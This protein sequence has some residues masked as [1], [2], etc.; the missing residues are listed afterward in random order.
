[1]GG[2]DYWALRFGQES[3]LVSAFVVWVCQGELD[4]DEEDCQGE[5]GSTRA[6]GESETRQKGTYHERRTILVHVMFWLP[7]P[8]DTIHFPSRPTAVVL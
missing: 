2:E 7:R 6:V 1:M 3:P 5:K 4:E 8:V